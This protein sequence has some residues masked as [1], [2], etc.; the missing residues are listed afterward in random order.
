ME[1]WIVRDWR[2]PVLDLD[3]LEERDG[4]VYR[5]SIL[6]N[7]SEINYAKDE[8]D[9]Q[10]N[11]D[12]PDNER[13]PLWFA[14]IPTPQLVIPDPNF[15]LSLFYCGEWFASRRMREVLALQEDEVVYRPA[16]LS[17]SAEPVR[18]LDYWAF[19]LI[20]H[21]DGIDPES[22]DVERI[23]GK[24]GEVL[25]WSPALLTGPNDP[26]PQ[27]NLRPD[28]VAPAPMFYMDRTDWLMVTDEL[29]QRIEAAGFDDVRFA[30]PTGE[31]GYPGVRW[32]DED[33]GRGR[34]QGGDSPTGLR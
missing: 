5:R 10:I 4:G 23:Y 12:T 20:E 34:P 27:V 11:P 13:G 9:A 16:D 19:T 30:P 28:F 14:A 3:V 8:V 17:G 1:V 24:N 7:E 6:R 32:L 21:A 2:Q 26:W 31:L 29:K 18:L 33:A 25:Y 22:S 15:A